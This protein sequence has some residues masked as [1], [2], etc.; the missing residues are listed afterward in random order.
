MMT[1]RF[2]MNVIKKKI[3]KTISFEKAAAFMFHFVESKHKKNLAAAADVLL[4]AQLGWVGLVF[5]F[6]IFLLL[7]PLQKMLSAAL[8]LSGVVPMLLDSLPRLS[9]RSQ[10]SP[11]IVSVSHLRTGTGPNT[12]KQ[13]LK[14]DQDQDLPSGQSIVKTDEESRDE[15]LNKIN[16]V[17]ESGPGRLFAVVHIRGFQHKVTDG[18]SQYLHFS[19]VINHSVVQVTY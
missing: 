14:S 11:L 18:N 5:Y 19:D 9:P 16:S 1:D 4:N 3:A 7:D 17:L 15:T 2:I 13:K 6:I 10:L 12:N 8:R